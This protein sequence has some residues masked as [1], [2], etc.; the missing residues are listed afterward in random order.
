MYMCVMGHVH[1]HVCNGTCVTFLQEA[2][3]ATHPDPP[4]ATTSRHG[5]LLPG[6]SKT[7]PH[8]LPQPRHVYSSY[9]YPPPSFS[10][11][12][13]GLLVEDLETSTEYETTP[14]PHSSIRNPLSPTKVLDST[15]K[16]SHIH[17]SLEGHAHKTRP[18]VSQ[19][20]HTINGQLNQLL[21][22]LHDMSVEY[23]PHPTDKGAWSGGRSHIDRDLHDKRQSHQGTVHVYKGPFFRDGINLQP[24][25]LHY[26]IISGCDL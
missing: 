6:D 9:P 13:E 14:I 12:G 10:S 26:I 3:P 22:R 11:T 7:R 24:L 25:E 5:N 19:T 2:D 15:V 18:D 4:L 1:V 16:G 20:I 8:P 21:V 23:V 17:Y